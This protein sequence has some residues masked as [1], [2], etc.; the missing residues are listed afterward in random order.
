[1]GRISLAMAVSLVCATG[2][3]ADVHGPI[4]F[5]QILDSD[6]PGSWTPTAISTIENRRH[7]L[8]LDA[9][10]QSLALSIDATSPTDLTVVDVSSL[11]GAGATYGD[12]LRSQ[13][14]ILDLNTAV[15]S[16][17]ELTFT[18]TLHPE[19]LSYHAVD[20]DAVADSTTASGVTVRD[21][22]SF[23]MPDQVTIAYL[24]FTFTGT[25]SATKSPR[26]QPLRLRRG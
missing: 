26:D 9:A 12:V 17:E 4:P 14:Q 23:Y 7:V 25:A 19:L 20:A 15:L 8:L 18:Y 13:L 1:M 10:T 6:F 11:T 16:E 21:R 24:V 3:G 2:F 5:A 22:G